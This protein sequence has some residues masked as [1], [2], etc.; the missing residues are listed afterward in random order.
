MNRC[1]TYKKGTNRD[2][3]LFF[4]AIK[5]AVALAVLLA[6]LEVRAMAG[7]D[8]PVMKR[9][10][11]AGVDA[12]RIERLANRA[13]SRDMTPAQLEQILLPVVSLAEM[14]L[15][16]DLVMQKAAEGLSKQVPATGILLVL[17]HMQGSMVRSVAIVDP[18]MGRREVQ[19]LIEAGRGART[20]AEATRQYRGMLLESASH[21]LQNNTDDGLLHEFLDEVASTNI[22]TKGGLAS[23]A[24]GL[25]ALS[26]MPMTKE[27][28]GLS[29]RLLVGA[30]N[31]GFTASEIREL[32][33]ALHSA[34]F[35]SRL[36]MERIA[37]GMDMQRYENIPAVHIMEYL[38]QGNT[39]GGP[40]GFQ[41]PDVPRD[42]ES[43]RSRDRMPPVPLLP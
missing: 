21:S 15:P 28:P 32:P 38:F 39:G 40:A 24:A 26:E 33:H 43:D 12:E 34:H 31:A 2:R 37:G 6:P 29:I 22:M 25:Q 20:T 9:A 1:F 5:A 14:G 41:A 8:D 19:H 13:Q 36:A 10:V 3:S 35:N 42:R 7:I 18:W 16:Y 11:D 27:N 30:M 4:M 23:I 17:D